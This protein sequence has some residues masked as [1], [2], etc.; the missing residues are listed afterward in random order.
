MKG[1]SEIK[2]CDTI[3]IFIV[4]LFL[5]ILV[6]EVR[7]TNLSGENFKVYKD[8]GYPELGFL[9]KPLREKKNRTDFTFPQQWKVYR[10]RR[11]IFGF[12]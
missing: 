1:N 2:W 8:D 5:G 12:R 3:I 6:I 7:R 4:I 11:G 10:R 9:D